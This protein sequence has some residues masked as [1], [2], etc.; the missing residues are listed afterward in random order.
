MSY[1][2]STLTNN[3]KQVNITFTITGIGF[4]FKTISC[5]FKDT[6]RALCKQMPTN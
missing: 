6:I 1:N 3:V 2:A 4:K 5:T